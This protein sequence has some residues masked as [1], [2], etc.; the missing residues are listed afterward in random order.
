MISPAAAPS[1]EARRIYGR[2]YVESLFDSIAPKY[3]ILNHLLSFGRDIL[4]RKRLVRALRSTAPRRILDVATGTADLAIAAATLR[5]QSIVGIDVSAAMLDL[6]NEKIRRKGLVPLL[7]VQ[8]AA[9]EHLP[10][11]DGSFDAVM[12]A[13][14][15]RN[16]TDLNGGLRE[17][18]RVLRPGGIA[19]ILEFSRPAGALVRGLYAAYS[20]SV[21][22][23][24]GGTIS[25][26]REAYRYLPDTVAQFPSGDAFATILQDAGFQTVSIHEQTFGIATLYL[27]SR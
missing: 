7:S 20:R 22:P 2:A 11:P 5:P 14:G 27:A 8:Q 3:D 17:M 15:V 24:L 12:V 9:A 25:G 19:A 16:F 26:N 18:A 1:A 23:S 6:A 21:I 4:W 10:F 13:F